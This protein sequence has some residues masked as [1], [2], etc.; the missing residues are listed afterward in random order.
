M[1]PSH[2]SFIRTSKTYLPQ[3]D[4]LLEKADAFRI[5]PEFIL[6]DKVNI[7]YWED[8]YVEFPLYQFFLT[9]QQEVVGNGNCVPLSLTAE[10]VSHL[11]EGGWDW[12]LERAFLDKKAGKKPNTLCVLQLGINKGYQGQGVSDTLVR[13][14][15]AIAKEQQFTQFIA[16]IRPHGK[17]QYPLQTMENYVSWTNAEGLPFDSWIQTHCKNGAQ[18]D[19]ICAKARQVEGTVQQWERWTKQSFQSSGKYIVDFALNPI[20]IDLEHNI[21]RY[22]EPHVWMKYSVE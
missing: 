22:T 11:P 8:L 21:G 19:K 6:Q 18:I 1:N 10:E 17:Q 4:V 15:K 16:P 14:M 13:F 7:K 20:E 2:F 12:A 5:W 9:D 3:Y